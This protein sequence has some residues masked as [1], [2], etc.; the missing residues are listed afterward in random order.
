M[1]ALQT[2]EMIREYRERAANYARMA[3]SPYSG[4]VRF[5]YSVI[6][7]HFTAL[8]NAVMRADRL[9]RKKRLEEMQAKRALRKRAWEASSAINRDL[10]RSSLV[11][12]N[13]KQITERL[14]IV[15][16]RRTSTSIGSVMRKEYRRRVLGEQ[17]NPTRN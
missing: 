11:R 17:S 7:D 6:A 16:N 5:R 4:D 14:R 10:L 3:D 15:D 13:F 12:I 1:S 9:E 2:F 8:A